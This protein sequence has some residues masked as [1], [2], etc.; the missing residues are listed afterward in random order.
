MAGSDLAMAKLA[1]NI[2]FVAVNNVTKLAERQ[3][4]APPSTI[5]LQLPQQATSSNLE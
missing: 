3:L 5:D 4:A 1:G 2:I